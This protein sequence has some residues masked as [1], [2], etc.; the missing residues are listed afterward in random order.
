MKQNNKQRLFEVMQKIDKT[1]KPVLNENINNPSGNADALNIGHN[2]YKDVKTLIDNHTSD[3]IWAGGANYALD[4]YIK[5]LDGVRDALYQ[6][7]GD[8]VNPNA[9][10]APDEMT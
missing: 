10:A 8:S 3:D 5:I 2:I 7:L 9:G 1:F 6:D 4:Y